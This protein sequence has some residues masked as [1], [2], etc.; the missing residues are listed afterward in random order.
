MEI[1]AVDERHLDRRTPQLRHRL[2]A[3]ETSADDDDV[4]VPGP[5]GAHSR[6]L[7]QAPGVDLV[8]FVARARRQEYCGE[9]PPTRE[10]V[11]VPAVPER[12]SP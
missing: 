1:A 7:F 9:V 12:R 11:V 4:V 2:Q 5:K 3:A 8:P 6:P 10:E